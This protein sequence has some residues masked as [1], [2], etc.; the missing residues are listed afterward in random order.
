MPIICT[1]FKYYS[2]KENRGL[3]IGLDRGVEDSVG[4]C[5]IIRGII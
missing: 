5:D 2:C 1:Y 3:A 4:K